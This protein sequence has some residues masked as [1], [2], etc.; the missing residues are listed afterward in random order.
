MK[1][2]LKPSLAGGFLQH[3][4]ILF[5]FLG[6]IG[7]GIFS[8]ALSANENGKGASVTLRPISETLSVSRKIDELVAAGLK[9]RNL[10]ANDP[11]SDEVFVRRVYLDIAGRIPSYEETVEFLEESSGNKRQHLIDQLLDSKG[12]VSHQFNYFADLLR[13]KSRLRNVPGQPFID[14]VKKS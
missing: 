5:A 8:A 1:R 10:Q 4:R 9:K 12:F 13:I 6:F 2:I 11:I 14:F 7:L 3:R